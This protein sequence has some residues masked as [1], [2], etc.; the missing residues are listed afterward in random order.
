[1][2]RQ[3][4]ILVAAFA[5][6]VL[7]A[8][9]QVKVVGGNGAGL[10]QIEGTA[11]LVT[12]VLK[13]TE[14]EDANLRVREVHGDYIT[15]VDAD[16]VK[17]HYRHEDIKE[18]RVQGGVVPVQEFKPSTSV[19]LSA[20]HQEDIQQLARAARE[21]FD[22]NTDNQGL[23]IRA[24]GILLAAGQ[25]NGEEGPEAYLDRLAR[26][27]DT[28]VGLEAG[29]RLYLGG[30][31][32]PESLMRSGLEGG[33]PR[34][35]AEAAYLSGLTGVHASDARLYRMLRDR[36]AEYASPAAR[37]LGLLGERDAIPALLDMIMSDD[38]EKGEA[39]KFALIHMGGEDLRTQLRIQLQDAEG[40]PRFRIIQ[41][42]YHLGDPEGRD[43]LREESMSVP[44]TRFRA[45]LILAPEGD[46]KAMQVL[47]EFLSERYE[48]DATV[49]LVR[50][51]QAAAALLA[52]DDRT[53]LGVLMELRQVDDE[54]VQRAVH[55]L[56]AET[57][58]DWLVNLT[59]PGLDSADAETR[60]LAARTVLALLEDDFRQRLLLLTAPERDIRIG[61]R[62]GQ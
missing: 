1:M 5:M 6:A 46:M 7:S 27:N 37:A 53:V 30:G 21:V 26:S 9:A 35:Q 34:V 4:T 50:R 59:I 28:E 11:T 54:E 8:S 10:R 45:A 62:E 58:K 33:N 18:V 55:D 19:G 32:V 60:L 57:G 48:P 12:V 16:G 20:Q 40:F 49:M 61:T 22:E 13:D 14:A 41:A 23:R 15:F 25:G 36:A 52:A 3:A 2:H 44:S 39:A 43:L 42:L 17:T 24:A 29:Y 47:R 31:E 56:I 38:S 51:A